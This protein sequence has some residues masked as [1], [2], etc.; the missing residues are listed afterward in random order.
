MTDPT[1]HELELLRQEAEAAGLPRPPVAEDR[2]V[3]LPD[4]SDLMTTPTREVRNSRRVRLAGLAL[5]AATVA[6][7]AAIIPTT[8]R[9]QAVAQPPPI[10]SYE[11]ANAKNI[12]W[13]PGKDATKPLEE[14]ARAAD[15]QAARSDARVPQDVDDLTQYVRIQAWYASI[16][17]DK[18]A[19]IVPEIRETW[20]RPDGNLQARE[21]S[22]ESLA[23]DGRDVPVLKEKPRVAV[24]TIPDLDP[25]AIRRLDL[26]PSEMRRQI[27]ERNK[28]DELGGSVSDRQLCFTGEIREAYG[29]Y[30]VPPETAAA[31]WRIL[32]HE[33]GFRSLGRVVDRARRAG[34][35]IAYHSEFPGQSYLNILI[36]SPRTGALLG[37]EMIALKSDPK[38]GFK[39][40]AIF[41]YDAFL[42]SHYTRS[43]GPL[44]Q[45]KPI[46]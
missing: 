36:I 46:E 19:H 23:I 27:W 18:E 34:V 4:A 39:A 29:S 35:G 3:V 5:A 33:P 15:R 42:D 10:L 40:P 1:D 38:I 22:S 44:P 37:T 13:A 43:R 12:A 8:H 21:S 28:C 45:Q 9:Q 16:Y 30:V 24:E 32:A 11:F 31:F 14:L 25:D 6:V 7:V 26:N 20:L 2:G 41:S 17:E